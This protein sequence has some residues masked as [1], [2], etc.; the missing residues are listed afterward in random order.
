[1]SLIDIEGHQVRDMWAVDAADRRRRLSV[2][3]TRDRCEP[4]F[5]AVGG[6][7]RDQ[8]GTPVLELA[9]DTS[10]GVHDMLFPRPGSICEAFWQALP[11]RGAP[12]R[13]MAGT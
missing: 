8:R 2:S 7:F 3:H 9:D 1:V 13:R 5:P 4:L 11:R 12:R 10:P 6:Q